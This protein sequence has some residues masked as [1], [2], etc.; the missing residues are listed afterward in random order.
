VPKEKEMYPEG[1]QTYIEVSQLTQH[2][3]GLS[4][5]GHFKGVTTVVAKLFN[6]IRPHIAFFGL[7][8]YQQYIVIKRMVKDLNYP[9]EIVGCPI[10]REPDGLVMSSRN[11]YLT[12]EQR[13][14]AL[15]LYQ[16]LKRAQEMVNQ[17]ERKAKTII[18]A[19]STFIQSYPYTKIDYV[20]LCDSETLEDLEEIR[21]KA[22]LAL[23]VQVGKAR[24]IDNTIIRA[25]L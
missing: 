9:I 21:E 19:V 5:P 15:S 11:V 20:K 10:V 22:F 23:A 2:L 17:G 25:K 24:L 3:C 7:K 8:D 4:R 6:I 12:T 14:S 18:K 1:Y 16:S 13:P